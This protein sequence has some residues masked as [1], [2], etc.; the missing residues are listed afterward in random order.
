[1]RIGLR[2][3]NLSIQ[4]KLR[5]ITLVTVATALL[6]AS[7]AIL[8]YDQ[9]STREAMLRDLSMRGSI[10]ASSSTAALSFGDQKAAVE[11]LSPPSSRPHVIK[12]LLYTGDR[13][14]FAAYRRNP[15]S[16]DPVLVGLRT[17]DVWF[18]GDRLR[19]FKPITL[20][21]QSI[22]FIYMESDL[23]ELHDRFRHFTEIVAI[24][25]LIASWLAMVLSSR[26]QRSISDPIAH[27]AE[28]ARVVSIAK[29]YHVRAIK[30]ADDDLGQFIGA[31]N[32]MLA[33]IERRDLALV[34][35]QERLEQEVASRIA[36]LSNSN[37]DLLIS[38]RKAEAASRAKSEFLA[39]M[40]HE[41]RTPM[42][43]II[44]M[45]E[46]V[47]DTN[48]TEEQ[49]EFLDTVRLSADSLLRVI[50]DILDFSKVEAG[51]MELDLVPFNLFRTVEES[52]KTVAFQAHEKG[53]E[54]LCDISP[55]VPEYVLGD[56]LRIRQIV[57]NLVGNAIKFTPS[58]EVELKVILDVLDDQTPDRLRLHFLVRDTGVGIAPDKLKLIFEPFSQ[59][60]TST[61]RS[62]G[63][64]GLGLT[65]STRL[66]EMMNGRLW[67]ESEPEQGSCFH[68]TACLGSAPQQLSQ[69][70]VARPSLAGVRVLLVDD[71]AANLNILSK[72]VSLWGMNPAAAG[73]GELALALMRHGLE[74]RN[75]F[76]LIISDVHMP[77]MD[78]FALAERI[79]HTPT[80]SDTVILLF[81]SAE[82]PGDRERS[83]RLGVFHH[84]TKPVRRE[85]LRSTI[86]LTLL[87]QAGTRRPNP[88]EV[89]GQK[90][91]S[92]CRILLV[93][94]NAVNQRLALR[95]LQR[96]GHNVALAGNGREAL[97]TL[98]NHTFDLVLMDVQ[99]PEM[100]GFEATRAIRASELG[101][102]AHLPIIA[103][104][105]HAMA[106]DRE[107]CISAGMDDYISKPVRASDLLD[108]IDKTRLRETAI[109]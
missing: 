98:Q 22:G 68:F 88:I 84:L 74:T 72:M 44:G 81:T 67:V 32:E 64:T 50:N 106:G 63:G 87:A 108:L 80:F 53:L 109:H 33:E 25:A 49:R 99:M 47:L 61:T 56:E 35:N 17:N 52:L 70:P 95:I 96:A 79:Q 89:E 48:P 23:L 24:I 27:L 40:S 29:N 19:L 104:T 9:F 54:L 85:E 37:A 73:G 82:M 103:M 18:E 90:D 94:D 83:R 20:G 71:N 42:N 31:F 39:N 41:I 30:T 86:E 3:R 102:S 62:F 13:K 38:M 36:E 76:S 45:T 34:D 6:L 2:Y 7:A 55:E 97:K 75:P 93:E 51:K 66:V 105:A 21:R 69:P 78:G 43:G 5:L 60:D 46:L 100:D 8:I 65:I 101:T 92:P 59:A 12:V 91:A 57:V 58:G 11:L 77:Q 28:V 15:H 14:L 1:M 26:L 16:P 4:H 107:R 10:L